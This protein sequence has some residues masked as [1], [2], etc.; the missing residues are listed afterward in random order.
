MYRLGNINKLRETLK[1]TAGKTGRSES[2]AKLLLPET[3]QILTTK[4]L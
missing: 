2:Y 4:S 3:K 1:P